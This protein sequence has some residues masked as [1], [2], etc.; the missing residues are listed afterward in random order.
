MCD[1]TGLSCPSYPLAQELQPPLTPQCL[2]QTAC[3]SLSILG[4]L[5]RVAIPTSTWLS[6]GKEST[7][8]IATSQSSLSAAFWAQVVV[9]AVELKLLSRT[10]GATTHPQGYCPTAPSCH[11]QRSSLFKIQVLALLS[12]FLSPSQTDGDVFLLL[13][14]SLIPTSED[15]S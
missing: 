6:A 13:G 2:L 1:C 3:S 5:R 9:T 10:K 15:T 4:A 8:D 11:S 12:L 7:V 14:C